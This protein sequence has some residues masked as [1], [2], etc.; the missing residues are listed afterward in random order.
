[1]IV[2][3]YPGYGKKKAQPTNSKQQQQQQKKPTSKKNP[4][5]NRKLRKKW[6]IQSLIMLGLG[7]SDF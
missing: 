6:P 4:Q 1:M 5:I 2:E 3:M 7:E